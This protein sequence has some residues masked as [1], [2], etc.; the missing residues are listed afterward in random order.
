ML[1]VRTNETVKEVKGDLIVKTISRENIWQAQTP[2]AF[3]FKLIKEAHDKSIDNATDDSM[4]VEKLGV[5]VKV[6]EPS[7]PNTKITSPADLAYVEAVLKS[8]QNG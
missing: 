2:Q 5:K 4:L 3:E 1:A 6:I 8:R 7:G